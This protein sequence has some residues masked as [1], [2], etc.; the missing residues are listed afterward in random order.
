MIK[1]TGTQRIF[2]YGTGET[3]PKGAIYLGT[4]T[5]QLMVGQD[6][7]DEKKYVWHY[8][9]VEEKPE[10]PDNLPTFDES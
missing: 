9:L 6:R 8:F 4:I 5:N 2:K 7:K 3:P 1:A 10:A